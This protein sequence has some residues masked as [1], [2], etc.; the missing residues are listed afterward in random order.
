M[1]TTEKSKAA[2]EI[3]R[4]I[5]DSSFTTTV[6]T[7]PRPWATTG[8]T[9]NKGIKM[10]LGQMYREQGRSGFPPEGM[11]ISPPSNDSRAMNG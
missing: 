7:Q 5:S 11:G 2:A 9:G 3:V 6:C 10:L 1:D 4:P 8:Y